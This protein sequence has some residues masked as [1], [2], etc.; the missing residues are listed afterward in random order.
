MKK[1]ITPTQLRDKMT[2]LSVGH[3]EKIKRCKG[4]GNP[5]VREMVTKWTAEK[6]LADAIVR[7]LNG[8]LV[9]LNNYF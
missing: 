6:E 3:D 7:A 2:A 4:D 5:Q 1:K 8:D 9:D